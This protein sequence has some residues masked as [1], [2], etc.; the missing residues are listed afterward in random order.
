MVDD[1]DR[2]DV[3]VDAVALPP[4][5][6]AVVDRQ[7]T[8]TTSVVRHRDP[9]KPPGRLR[10]WGSHIVVGDE[11]R[12]VHVSNA[13]TTPVTVPGLDRVCSA[14]GDTIRY[15]VG[16]QRGELVVVRECGG[17]W[18]RLP[19][20][21]DGNTGLGGRIETHARGEG[22]AVIWR[23]A[24][25]ACCHWWTAHGWITPRQ[26]AKQ[27]LISADR[28]WLGSGHGEF[29]GSIKRM[30][31]TG[32]EFDLE[33]RMH[34]P[35]VSLAWTAGNSVVVGVA[36]AHMN[37][38]SMYIGVVEPNG[39]MTPRFASDDSAAYIALETR[40]GRPTA[41]PSV[42][43]S[44]LEAIRRELRPAWQRPQDTLV[45]VDADEH[46]RVYF[47]TDANGLF[48]IDGDT[49]TALTPTW[50]RPQRFEDAT[51]VVTEDAA[52]ISSSQGLLL[53]RFGGAKAMSIVIPQ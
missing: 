28:L 31:A 24:G 33:I 17:S 43:P 38:K 16:E 23:R 10:R 1:D 29:G 42:K 4:E 39:R 9:L 13:S 20:L 12:I 46:G 18:E 34:L 26:F 30:A 8:A 7:R 44:D 41:F 2:D 5:L 47:L 25:Q 52:V 53:C 36:L 11:P 14:A 35:V 45:A 49:L 22:L 32:T 3:F 21:P 50:T 37:S 15:A 40:A 51:L 48:R 27:M 6:A 19:P